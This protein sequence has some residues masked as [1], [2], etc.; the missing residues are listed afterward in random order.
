MGFN[1]GFMAVLLLFLLPSNLLFQLG[2]GYD[3]PDSFAAL[4][5]RPATYLTAFG[6]V[7][8]ILAVRQRKTVAGFAEWR[9][10]SSLSY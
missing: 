8:T 1:Y 6:L 5:I 4:K 10:P 2:I 3:V 9:V 7:S